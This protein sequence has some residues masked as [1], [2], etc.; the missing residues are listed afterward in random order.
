METTE[1]VLEAYENKKVSKFKDPLMSK[2]I[3]STSYVSTKVLNEVILV[4]RM[5]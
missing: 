5:Q 4:T 1:D 2:L 3:G